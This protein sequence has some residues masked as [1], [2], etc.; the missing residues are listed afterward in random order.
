MLSLSRTHDCDLITRVSKVGQGST[1]NTNAGAVY[2]FVKPP[3]GWADSNETA[4]LTASDAAISNWFGR[5]VDIS[6]DTI[7][8][9]AF[10]SDFFGGSGLGSAYVFM[11]PAEGWSSMTETT[12]LDDPDLIPG[13]GYGISVAIDGE[14]VVIGAYT[15]N[16]TSPEEAG[17]VFVG[18][19]P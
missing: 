6:G 4:K 10:K 18:R 19:I 16:Y 9:G 3:T 1:G 14:T 5:S 8:V 13:D 15:R 17:V 7:A 12:R 2:V 11:K